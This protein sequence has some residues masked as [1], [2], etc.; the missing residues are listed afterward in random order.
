MARDPSPPPLRTIGRLS[1]ETGVK[2]PTIRFYEKIGLLEEP[3][4]T[5]S[6]R[7]LYDG[8]ATRR[9]AFIRHARQLGFEID[10]IR[11][12]LALSDEP[13]QPC[14]E[15]NRI[16]ERQLAAVETRIAG[17][18]ALHAE[19]TRIQAASCS[20][21]RISDCRVIEALGNHAHC[22]GHTD[23]DRAGARPEHIVDDVDDRGF[24]S[25]APSGPLPLFAAASAEA[26]ELVPEVDE[27]DAALPAMPAGQEVVE[28]YTHVGVTLR[29]HPLAFLRD[30]LQVRHVMTCAD[31]TAMRDRRL[32]RVAG[33]VLVRQKPGSAK[34]VMFITIEDETGVA[35][36]VIWPSLYEQQRRV[37]LGAS[38]LVVDGRVQREGEVVHIVAERLHDGSDLLASLGRRGEFRLPHGRGDEVYRGSKPDARTPKARDIY[39]PD[40]SLEGI[41]VRTRDFR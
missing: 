10:D 24:A 13:D 5:A 28:D 23:S 31:G 20:G 14:T 39:I 19:L 21:G 1:A 6:D 22:D 26:G 27:P 30:E 35:N 17:L 18:Q 16:A 41:R 2:V 12:L 38:L 33:L 8:A 7:R 3:P 36:L 29:D 9:L 34:G 15:V 40:L 32:T 25:A 37:V 11:A 4:R